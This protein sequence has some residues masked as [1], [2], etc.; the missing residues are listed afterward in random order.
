MRDGSPHYTLYHTMERL[1]F[2]SLVF[3]VSKSLYVIAINRIHIKVK[4][5]W[6]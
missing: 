3:Q 5:K 2:V 1:H 6:L 4:A